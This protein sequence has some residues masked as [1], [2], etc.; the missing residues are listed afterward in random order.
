MFSHESYKEGF[1]V[2]ELE[3]K[4]A[5]QDHFQGIDLSFLD[6]EEVPEDEPANVTTESPSAE[7]TASDPT[8]VLKPNQ[9]IQPLALSLLTL[10]LLP[11]LSPPS[12]LPIPVRRLKIELL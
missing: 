12:P 11:G 7:T 6:K 8:I 4:T 9:L 1:E 3:C 5:I 2:G 10:I